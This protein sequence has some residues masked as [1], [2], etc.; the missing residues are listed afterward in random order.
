MFLALTTLV[1]SAARIAAVA[2]ISKVLVW[3][4]IP[5]LSVRHY[6]FLVQQ[7]IISPDPS[8]NPQCQTKWQAQCCVRWTPGTY[9]A[10]NSFKSSWQILTTLPHFA[11][12]LNQNL[13]FCH[14]PSMPENSKIMLSGTLFFTCLIIPL[15]RMVVSW[16]WDVPDWLHGLRAHQDVPQNYY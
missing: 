13:L 14:W 9:V 6:Q 12:I 1:G 8:A 10:Q 7:I 3:G 15:F 2:I 16:R 11:E 4:T 5:L